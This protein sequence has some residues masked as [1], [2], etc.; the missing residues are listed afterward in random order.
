MEIADGV[1]SMGNEKGGHVRAFLLDDGRD[2]TL[3]DTLFETDARLVLEQSRTH[4]QDGRGPEAHPADARPSLAPRR[5]GRARASERGVG[6]LPRVGGG[7][8]RRRA[9]GAGLRETTAAPLPRLP[10]GVPAPGSL[11][12]GAGRPS[13]LP[14]RPHPGGRRPGRPRPGPPHARTLAGSPRLL[15]A[16]VAGPL[17]WRCHLHLAE[18]RRGLAGSQPQPR[19]AP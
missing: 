19:T 15:L 8:R 4:E 7:H 9:Q 11:R 10:A 3:I 16:G 5:A 17:R 18:L 12:A 14:R 1:Y 2:L 6:L 13:A